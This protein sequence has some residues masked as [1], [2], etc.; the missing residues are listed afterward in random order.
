MS[1]GLLEESGP[2]EEWGAPSGGGGP[3][4]ELSSFQISPISA[5]SL[6][7]SAPNAE[8]G[9]E[10]SRVETAPAYFRSLITTLHDNP[11]S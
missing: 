4:E 11:I 5:E 3:L 2:I 7:E 8:S 6:N 9:T 10:S 1:R